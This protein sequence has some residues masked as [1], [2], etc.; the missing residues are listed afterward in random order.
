MYYFWK[1]KFEKSQEIVK[2]VPRTASFFALG[3]YFFDCVNV[4][5]RVP[6]GFIFAVAKFSILAMIV[7]HEIAPFLPF[8]RVYIFYLGA[9]GMWLLLSKIYRNNSSRKMSICN[10]V[11][12]LIWVITPAV[13]IGILRYD[14]NLLNWVN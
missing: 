11:M 9:T 6:T 10:S 12:S 14:P 3:T 2:L 4:L 7:K 8:V 13:I 5:G 1:H